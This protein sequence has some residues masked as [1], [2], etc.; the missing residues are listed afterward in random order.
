MVLTSFP[1]GLLMSYLPTRLLVVGFSVVALACHDPVVPTDPTAPAPAGDRAAIVQSS[2][3][4][5][6]AFGGGPSNNGLVVAVGPEDAV[7]ANRQQCL[8]GSNDVPTSQGKSVLVFT[9][10]G[11]VHN[12]SHTLDAAVSVFAAGSIQSFCDLVGAPVVATG[13][14]RYTTTFNDESMSPPGAVTFGVTVSGIVTLTAGGEA[15][16]FGE[17]RIVILPDG[18]L[19]VD[20][21]VVRLTPL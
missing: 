16:L 2:S 6:F 4:Q 14:V 13:R 21:E 11:N 3:V 19:V 1:E 5:G 12:K 20:R 9:P 8:T 10:S 7:E 15:R 18:S 17:S